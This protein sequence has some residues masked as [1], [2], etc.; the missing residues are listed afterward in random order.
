MQNNYVKE[1]ATKSYQE[2]LAREYIAA[3]KYSFHSPS[4]FTGLLAAVLLVG[5]F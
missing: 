1:L 2:D 3:R 4:F 5:L